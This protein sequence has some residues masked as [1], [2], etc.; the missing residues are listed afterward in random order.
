MKQCDDMLPE[1]KEPQHEELITLLQR[2]YS[3]PVFVPPAEQ[4]QIINRVR[5]RLI[6]TDLRDSLNED[7]PVSQIGV[8]DSFPHKP[9]SPAGMPRRDLPR[10]RLIALLAASLVIA[11]FLGSSLLYLRHRLPPTGGAP[12]L[13]L[14]SNVANVGGTVTLT[15]EH[16]SHSAPVALTPY[17]LEPI[18]IN[19]NSSVITT[20][21]KGM[22]KL[23]LAINKYWAPGFHPIVA[24]SVSPRSTST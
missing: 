2:A 4:E 6:E 8:L 21:S 7:R 13:T 24:E 1:E 9:V 14:S 18:Q 22:T 11:V 15:I 5:E 16:F 3:R 12:A 20:D 10:F 17:I 19:D 23:H